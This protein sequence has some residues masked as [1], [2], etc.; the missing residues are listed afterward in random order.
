MIFNSTDSIIFCEPSPKY[1]L[2]QIVGADL[3]EIQ[4]QLDSLETKID[5]E[6]VCQFLTF[7][8]NVMFLEFDVAVRHSVRD[9][10]L[11][12]G[13]VPAYKVRLARFDS[14][15]GF[16]GHKR[17]NILSSQITGNYKIAL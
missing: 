17:C 4:R 2:C 8:R 15:A 5:P 9:T 6:Q 10:F 1:L 7:R 13:N 12:T 16:F 14:V 3:R 11:A